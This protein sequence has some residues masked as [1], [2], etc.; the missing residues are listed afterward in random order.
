MGGGFFGER[1]DTYD[2]YYPGIE[3]EFFPIETTLV[4]KLIVSSTGKKNPVVLLITTAS[5]DGEHDVDLYVSAFRKQYESLGAKIEEL[6]LIQWQE[7]P[8]TV[9][10]KIAR[11]DAVY[12]S[13]GDTTLLIKTWRN[14]GVDKLLRE[15]Y[16]SGTIMSGLSAGACCWFNSFARNPQQASLLKRSALGWIDGLLCVHFDTE[17]SRQASFKSILAE[18]TSLIGIALDEHTAIEIVDDEYRV[19]TYGK[20]SFVRKCYWEKGD[21]VVE[22]LREIENFLPMKDLRKR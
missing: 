6:R 15:A 7:S 5:E 12:V 8:E 9:A 18:D 13:C 17:T 14:L 4:D 3:K 10:A 11:A 1:K 16:E 21:Y 22:K 2:D 19:H 20:E